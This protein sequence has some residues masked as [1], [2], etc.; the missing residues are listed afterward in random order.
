MRRLLTLALLGAVLPAVPAA[1]QAPAPDGTPAAPPATTGDGATPPATG[2]ASPSSVG[3]TS[4]S[5][6]VVLA[7]AARVTAR[8][9]VTLRSAP[10]AGGRSLGKLG[11]A[12]AT[13]VACHTVGAAYSSPSGPS[14]VWDRVVRP[15]GKT[16]WV[17]DG[18][19]TTGTDALVAPL[20][21][22]PAV[23]P[24]LLP[25]QTTGVCGIVAPVTVLPP[26]PGVGS[27]LAAALP[28]AQASRDEYRVPVSVTLAQGILE[29]G[30]GRFTAGGNNFFGLK[31]QA[32]G[33]Q[34]WSFGTHAAGCV[35]KKTMEAEGGRLVRTIGAFRS[36]TSLEGSI[37]DHGERLATN[38]VYA[39]AFSQTDPRRFAQVIARHYATD[40]AYASKLLALMDRYELQQYDA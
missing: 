5:A 18:Y 15:G 19:L 9:A 22:A 2:G 1:A 31:A 32:A 40:P 36:Y 3:P 6:P 28:G 33:P 17:A 39:S 7:T 11:R 38:P 20:C 30:G 23:P 4:S 29:T 8:A 35:L 10:R 13:Q 27:F 34:L 16:A 21:G 12:A 25:R 24:A 14:R 37:L 26:F